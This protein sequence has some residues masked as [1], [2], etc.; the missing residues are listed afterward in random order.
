MLEQ[1]VKKMK[2]G[3]DVTAKAENFQMEIGAD[4]AQNK[5][6]RGEAQKNYHLN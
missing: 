6:K 1:N 4:T 5:H 2:H 3:E